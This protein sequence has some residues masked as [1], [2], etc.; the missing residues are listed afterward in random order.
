MESKCYSLLA[1]SFKEIVT[2]NIKEHITDMK[3]VEQ[4]LFFGFGYI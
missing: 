1:T 4:L 3:W 2:S